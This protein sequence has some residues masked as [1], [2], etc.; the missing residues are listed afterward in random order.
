MNTITSA[1]ADRPIERLVMLASLESPDAPESLR[2]TGFVSKEEPPDAAGM[3]RV[4]AVDDDRGFREEIRELLEEEGFDVVGEAGDGAEAVDLAARLHPDVILMDLRMPNIDGI[5]ATRLIKSEQPMTQV[6]MLSAYD[7][8]G[9]QDG[10]G[11]V[12]VYCYL[13]KGCRASLIK[14]VLL[15][16]WSFKTGLEE[17]AKR[18]SQ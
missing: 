7:D 14:D 1:T 8:P 5:E 12:G 2:A 11:E 15:R 17:R 4:L 10:A 16:A 6:V 9:L 18:P 3:L 13:V